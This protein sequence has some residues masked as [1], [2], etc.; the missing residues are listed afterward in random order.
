MRLSWQ[1]KCHV[2]AGRNKSS[3]NKEFFFFFNRN[4]V[5]NGFV[6]S[7]LVFL[8]K[9]YH[10][11]CCHFC[12]KKL[13]YFGKTNK[14]EFFRETIASFRQTSL[15][16]TQSKADTSL[17]KK[18][19]DQ[20]H[21]VDSMGCP[22]IQPPMI[23]CPQNLKE[24]HCLIVWQGVSGQWTFSYHLPCQ[25]PS[26]RHY[27]KVERKG[28]GEKKRGKEEGEGM[29]WGTG[30]SKWLPGKNAIWGEVHYWRM[31]L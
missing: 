26:V 30:V 22:A 14:E 6:F 5:G 24:Q 15:Y 11:G 10:L 21:E 8:S 23:C 16:E 7:N 4:T 3:Q 13:Q 28:K 25:Q 9:N 1:A 2:L 17:G 20:P 18:W 31:F 29:C 27:G 12:F 19:V